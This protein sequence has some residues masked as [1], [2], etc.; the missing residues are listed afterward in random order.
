MKGPLFVVI[1]AIL[2]AIGFW[3]I[4]DAAPERQGRLPRPPRN[5]LAPM[6]PYEG[7][8]A[9]PEIPPDLQ[10]WNA[11]RPIRLEELRG[12]VLLLDF[13]THGVGDAT[14]R[15]QAL[16]A[17]EERY[18]AE[19]VVIGVHPGDLRGDDSALRSRVLAQGVEHPVVGDPH[20]A[21]WQRF[22][23]R[24]EP[25]LAIIDPNGK[26]VG[27][28]AGQV[29]AERLDRI[30]ASVIRTFDARGQIDRRHLGPRSR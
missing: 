24:T 9:A 30:V 23:V 29:T 21:V 28:H 17:V 19:V 12:K 26:I 1:P 27:Y 10:W 22:A 25:T 14:P 5:E 16:R 15:L 13:S 20:K 7:R 11:Q 18:A 4:V 3:W 2:A 6:S 8:A